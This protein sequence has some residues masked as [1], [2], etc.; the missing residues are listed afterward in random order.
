MGLVT[1]CSSAALADNFSLKPVAGATWN[2]ELSKVPTL[3]QADDA[4][5]QIWDTDLYDTPKETIAAFKAKGHPY[6]CYF[7]A[8]S[9]ERWRPDADEFP[10]KALGKKL[11]GWP[12]ERWLDTTNPAVRQ[13]MKKRIELAVSKGCDGVDPDNIDGYE[14]PTGFHLTKH[15]GVDYVN[16][17]AKTAHDAGLSYGLKNGGEILERVV[18]VSQWSI[19][20]QC[21]RYNECDLYQ[22]F[23]KQNKPVFH[24]EYTAKNP[25]PASFVKKSCDNAGAKGFSTLIKHLSLN[26]WTT[27]CPA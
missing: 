27:T 13:I 4:S 7:S 11:D 25:A 3:A 14:N 19:N 17:L 2:I 6:I 23:I 5:F 8:G 24:I 9:W 22:P 16:F 20:E 15:D 18:D 21:V 26:A 1:E 10:K 12:G